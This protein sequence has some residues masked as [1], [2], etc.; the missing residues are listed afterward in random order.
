LVK[1]ERKDDGVFFLSSQEV[2]EAFCYYSISQINPDFKYSF[3][4]FTS[5]NREDIFFKV[6]LNKDSEMNLRITQPFKR[7]ITDPDYN[8][9]P[10][11]FEVGKIEN[12]GSVTFLSEGH[13]RTFWGAKSVHA[14]PDITKQLTK[15]SYLVRIRMLWKNSNKYNSA[16]LAAYAN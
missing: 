5:G 4:P 11:A 8:H 3:L 9:S 15:G 13:S 2:L 10:M 6:T 14:F 7:M 16:V 12:D 1:F